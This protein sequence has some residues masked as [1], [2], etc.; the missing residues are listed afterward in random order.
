MMPC[1]QG[2]SMHAGARF[3]AKPAAWIKNPRTKFSDFLVRVK[4]LE[5]FTRASQRQMEKECYFGAVLFSQWLNAIVLQAKPKI[6][7]R[8]GV[9]N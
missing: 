1:A 4:G 8:F 5:L 6:A 3:H 9:T 2:D 7:V